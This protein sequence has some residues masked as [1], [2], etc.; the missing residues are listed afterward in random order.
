M[1]SASIKDRN[2]PTDQILYILIFEEEK[3]IVKA[4]IKL[5][6]RCPAASLLAQ[7]CPAT[8]VC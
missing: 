2:I 3:I 7:M 1:A 4:K 6:P 5:G 8:S